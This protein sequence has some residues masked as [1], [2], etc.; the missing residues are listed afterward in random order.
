MAAIASTVYL[1][2]YW[3]PGVSDDLLNW[4]GPF[5]LVAKIFFVLFL[6]IWFRWTWPR[7]REDQL[8]GLAWKWLIPLT[9]FNI[10]AT[11]TLK[12]VL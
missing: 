10:M 5:I 8:Q 9:L 6:F 4:L 7:V 2:G 11:A 12:V 3:L 1:G